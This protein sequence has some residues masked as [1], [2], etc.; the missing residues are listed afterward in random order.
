MSKL[1]SAITSNNN[2]LSFPATRAINATGPLVQDGT[3]IVADVVN[4]F[5][6]EKQSLLDFYE[7]TPN[8][9][10]DVAGLDPG[11]NLPNSQPLAIN[12]MNY[13]TPGSIIAWASDKDP[14]LLGVDLTFDF[15]VRLLL[16]QGQG[17]DRTLDDY[18]LLDSIVYVGDPDN[19]TADSFYHADDAGGTSR[20]PAGDYLILPDG[21]GQTLR[22]LD[23]TG[24]VD[25]EGAG[26][27]VGSFQDDKFQNITASFLTKKTAPGSGNNTE[28]IIEDPAVPDVFSVT[29]NA[30]GLFPPSEYINKTIGPAN[31]DKIFFD[32]SADPALRTGTENISKNLAV[33]Y[34]IH[35]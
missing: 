30:I 8:D 18:R 24:T 6:L 12:L 10:F 19:G 15:T 7:D 25:P 32:T 3:E 33:N 5:W 14:A 35:Y 16:L 11:N 1:Y 26:R 2:D 9:L 20:N 23:E 13:G 22:G 34:A 28:I 31:A 17:I 4:D 27:I 21:R 29:P